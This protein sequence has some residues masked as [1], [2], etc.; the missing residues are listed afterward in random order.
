M[1]TISVYAI[2]YVNICLTP[3]SLS[4]NYNLVY[5]SISLPFQLV[6]I[7]SHQPNAYAI[8]EQIQDF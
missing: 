3:L 7:T 4:E 2:S 1:L 6:N 5:T 8:D